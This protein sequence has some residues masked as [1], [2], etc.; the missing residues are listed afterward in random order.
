MDEAGQVDNPAWAAAWNWGGAVFW[1]VR[2]GQ[3]Q[4]GRPGG[5]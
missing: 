1:A 4:I 2:E 3:G 5:P